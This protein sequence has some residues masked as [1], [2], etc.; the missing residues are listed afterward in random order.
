VLS[1]HVDH[2]GIQPAAAEADSIYNGADDDASGVVA[3]LAI[4]K[5]IAEGRLKPDGPI[6]FAAFSNE[7]GGLRGSDY[8]YKSGVLPVQRIE[9]NLNLEMLGR[10]DEFG[11]NKYYIT[12]PEHSN[13]QEITVNFNKDR[14]WKMAEVDGRILGALF[15]MAD[16]YR[17]VEQAERSGVRVPAHTI[18]TS[19]GMWHIHRADDE[20]EYIDFDNLSAAADNLTQLVLHLSEKEVEVRCH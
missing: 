4:A 17:L 10:S 9:A 11:P 1:A 8:F 13:L 12:G 2:I 16:N 15:K 7:E 5:N 18:A 14:D 20:I 3:M 19:V 6:V